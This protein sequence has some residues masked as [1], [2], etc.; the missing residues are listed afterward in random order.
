MSLEKDILLQFKHNY[1]KDRDMMLMER[2]MMNKKEEEKVKEYMRKRR[3][4]IKHKF[5]CIVR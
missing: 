1:N 4:N 3:K 5:D 2:I